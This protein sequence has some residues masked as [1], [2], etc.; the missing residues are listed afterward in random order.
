M[1]S[2]KVDKEDRAAESRRL[3]LDR[4]DALELKV[5]SLKEAKDKLENK[6]E[7]L[8]AKL[9]VRADIDAFA[10]RNQVG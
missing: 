1:N 2:V 7:K 9:G 3:S 6:V 4:S 5:R 8:E 10:Y